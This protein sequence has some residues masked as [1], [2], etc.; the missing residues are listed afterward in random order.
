MVLL[1]L[2]SFILKES[3][4]NMYLNNK[5]T[6]Y[7]VYTVSNIIQDV[8]ELALILSRDR[9]LLRFLLRNNLLLTTSTKTV[10]ASLN[11]S[12]PDRCNYISE[13]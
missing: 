10:I 1:S 6:T 2:V 11:K 13:M 9:F 5:L 4:F 8:N 7:N 12:F 3:H